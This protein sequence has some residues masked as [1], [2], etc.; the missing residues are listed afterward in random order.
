MTHK[1]AKLGIWKLAALSA[2]GIL[3]IALAISMLTST[4]LLTS[5]QEG[6]TKASQQPFGTY[7]KN[8]PPRHPSPSLLSDLYGATIPSVAVAKQLSGLDI[9]V[10]SYTPIDL[11][12]KM[13]KARIE[14]ENQVKMLTLIYAPTQIGI[15]EKST[16]EDIMDFNGLIVVYTKELPGF[17]VTKW[18]DEYAKNTP[19]A[20]LVTVKGA[21]A[22]GFDGDP[23]TG[24]KSQVIFYDGEIQVIVFSVA[25]QMAELLKIAESMT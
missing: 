20:H 21:K 7:S 4:T 23:A 18:I 13:V 14:P 1:H 12:L 15:N 2:V 5:E 24:K 6:N 9:K 17:D 16:V 25:Y 19:T 8:L 3:G 10:P 22:I 11:D